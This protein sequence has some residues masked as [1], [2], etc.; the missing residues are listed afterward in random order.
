V[1]KANQ[2]G[3]PVIIVSLLEKQPDIEVVLYRLRQHR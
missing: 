3:I 1:V 2:L